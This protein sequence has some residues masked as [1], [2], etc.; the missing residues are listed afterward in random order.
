MMPYDSK[1]RQDAISI[2]DSSVLASRKDKRSFFETL[3]LL[4]PT[5][6]GSGKIIKSNIPSV[7]L[8]LAEEDITKEDLTNSFTDGNEKEESKTH[9]SVP[10]RPK[11][12]ESFHRPVRFNKPKEPMLKTDTKR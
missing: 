9:L 1:V 12:S 8:S 4:T 7:A 3:D 6:I 11:T 2:I 10:S 5:S